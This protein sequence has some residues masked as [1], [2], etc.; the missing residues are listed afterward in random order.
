MQLNWEKIDRDIW[1]GELNE[2]IPDKIFDF[3]CHIFDLKHFRQPYPAEPKILKRYSKVKLMD[4]QN[5]NKVF[6]PG[7]E[8]RYLITG[9]PHHQSDLNKQNEFVFNEIKKS[10]EKEVYG[11]LLITPEMETKYLIRKIEKENFAGFKPYKCFSRS[12]PE[13]SRIKDFFTEEQ[14]EI[15]NQY[16]L[17]VT[18]HLSMK[19]GIADPVNL[20]DM[21]F[22][23][24]RYPNITWN[25][26]H[27]GRSF[28]P[29]NLEKVLP[30]LKGWDKKNI[31]Y[32][33]SAVT[34][35][36]VF[37]LLLSELGAKKVLF[38]S[39]NPIGFLRGK[40]IGLGYD[41]A[42]ITE[43]KFSL[44]ES[45]GKVSPTFL[46][47]EELRALKRASQRAGLLKKEIEK[48]FYGNA[49]NLLERRF[50]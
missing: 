43:D 35:S 39:D 32:D 7:R 44:K 38:G 5:G 45:F 25:L 22:L 19:K 41:W 16:R 21:E 8:T 20:D 9:W 33:I 10:S 42:F 12:L 36:E 30:V 49:E 26:A 29:E 47:Y 40:C 17:I 27:C 50:L 2:F 24:S 15:A 11:L 34:N 13:N 37:Y 1:E 28:I 6:F 48:M 31:Y 3:H 18:L 23:S 14:M 46:L 4:F